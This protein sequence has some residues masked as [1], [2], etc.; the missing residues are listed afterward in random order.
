MVGL[1]IALIC[2]KFMSSFNL[3]III[4][5]SFSLYGVGFMLTMIWLVNFTRVLFLRNT[6]SCSRRP[7]H[8]HSLRRV[9]RN[10]RSFCQRRLVAE[11]ML[12][13]SAFNSL[14]LLYCSMHLTSKW[15]LECSCT[16]WQCLVDFWTFIFV[17]YSKFS[18]PLFCCVAS[19][20]CAPCH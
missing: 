4:K 13:F 1:L 8:H 3:Q 10:R 18:A 20:Q 16:E 6:V 11:G 5:T 19:V 2:Y 17:V 7:R 12:P 9:A 14:Y 15:S